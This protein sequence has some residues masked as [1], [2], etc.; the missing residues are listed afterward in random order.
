[1]KI[2]HEMKIGVKYS[3]THNNISVYN[4]GKFKNK[5]ILIILQNKERT[6]ILTY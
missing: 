3:K 2:T 1:M 5:N 4:C 6:V